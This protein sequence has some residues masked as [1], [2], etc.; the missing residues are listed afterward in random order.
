MIQLPVLTHWGAIILEGDSTLLHRIRTVRTTTAA[1]AQ[2]TSKRDVPDYMF[3]IKEAWEKTNPDSLANWEALRRQL[4][5]DWSEI[6]EF[7]RKVLLEVAKIPIGETRSY[8]DIAVAI[9]DP[10]SSR[11]VGGAIAKNPFWPLIP[12]HRVIQKNG[13]LGAY[14]GVGG[15]K[16]KSWILAMER[17]SNFE[18]QAQR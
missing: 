15:E 3:K 11:A 18:N 14:S 10:N 6:S 13:K 12:C 9:G 5:F 1:K 17:I 2:K 4:N 7:Q 8:Q 16:F